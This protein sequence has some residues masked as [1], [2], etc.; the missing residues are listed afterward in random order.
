MATKQE[1]V[2][3]ILD[4]HFIFSPLSP[5]DKRAIEDLFEIEKYPAGGAIAEAGRP[6]TGLYS[7]YSGSIRMKGFNDSGKRISLGEQA[8]DS[9]FGEI[10]L[11]T[12]TNWDQQ[13]VASSDAILLK[14][15]SSKLRQFLRL[16]PHLEQHFRQQ[17]GTI[18][19]RKRLRGIL[20][21]AQYS[22][23]LA[24]E[25]LNNIG[26]KKI[27]R[28]TYAFKQGDE[29]PRL[30][31]IEGGSAELVRDM[32]EGTVVL[33]KVS[34]GGLIGETGAVT[35]QPQNYSALAVTD[36][37][38]LVIRAPEVK[39]ILDTNFE[40]KE[41][42]DQ[43]IRQ[44]KEKEKDHASALK[45]QEGM[46]QRIHLDAISESDFKRLAKKT[47]V[48]KFKVLKQGAPNEN[49]ATCL[50]MIST[51]FGKPFTIGQV[52]EIANINTETATLPQVC[53]AGEQMGF[54]T[55]YY[56]VKYDQLRQLELPAIILWEN[57][58]Y[59]VIYRATESAIYVAD[60]LT[61]LKTINRREFEAGW[62]GV[63]VVTEPTQKFKTLDAPEHPYGRFIGFLLPYKF[64]FAEAFLAVLVMNI[65]G[66]ASPLFV[67]NI[68]DKV[69]VH[70]D[71]ALLNM[72]LLGMVMVTLFT[73]ITSAA[74]SLL[75]AHV[76]A[77]IDM[78]MMSEFYRH[79]LSL[80]LR[81]FQSR[82]IG[83]ILSRFGENQKI[84]GILAGTT[85]TA[86]LD[87]LMIVLYIMMMLIYNKMLTIMVIC[88]IPI[89]IFN[90]LF[91]TP[92]LNDIYNQLFLSNAASQ[93]SLIESLHG[94]EA[95]K[96][97]ANEYWARSRWE[98]AFVENVNLGYKCAKVSLLFGI[99]S[100]LINLSA[101]I[102]IL[103]VG[104]NEVIEDKLSI[105]ELMGFNILM[106]EVM[107]PILNMVN[108]WSSL[109][110]IRIAMDRVNDV[111]IVK[112]EQSFV[113]SSG[114]PPAV[115]SKLEGRIEFRNTCFR[116]GGEDTPLILNNFN[117]IIEPG[118]SVAFVGP[119][120]C[121][122]STAIK[123]IMGF[124]MPTGGECLVDGKDITAIDL[125]SYRR[126]IGVVLQDSY[127]FSDTVAGNIALGDTEPDMNAV[128][129]AARLSSADDFIA[130]L[131]QG[132][133]TPLGEKGIQVSGGQRQ[134]ICIAR[135]LYRRPKI[136]IF[137]EATSALDN[138]SE[139]RIQQNMKAIL[140]GKT[141][142][143]I[144]HRLSTVRDCDF[145]CFMENGQVQEKGNH[146]E[147][148][149]M[150]G[151]YYELAKKQFDL[152]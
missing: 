108:L 119:S 46:D 152:E 139:A 69:V 140:T 70:K 94:I 109:A 62:D 68:V 133:Q 59:V 36:L 89:Y 7:V 15:P 136:L 150:K 45:R 5:T 113:T 42:L 49:V 39:K 80:P 56:N 54:R 128:R 24:T 79:I 145:I 44:L 55:K 28:G 19:M 141:S 138:E 147:L 90:T 37:T 18:E 135:A 53:S 77:R 12:D 110:E 114:A 35:G 151:R 14:L 92:R 1:E 25:I 61:G 99:I 87:A 100:Q 63:V 16:N 143:A 117:L 111:A 11:L 129:D 34:R 71:A 29:D 121:G 118:Q 146:D 2:R 86:V 124:N 31:Y 74:Q 48:G 40:L 130:R 103:W 47:E 102:S 98:D 91:F 67:Q 81:F 115:V 134:R 144:A 104:A 85:I 101:N 96:S 120:G 95:I 106:G 9:T 58:H 27:K 43:R 33:E 3:K 4:T 76:I 66:L 17:I 6:M 60:P 78:K 126:Q 22:P 32:I 84:R 142:I 41:K 65:L 23:D 26:V 123:M 30:Y 137:D 116:Y 13:I 82:Q 88:F 50:A 72:M 127:L 73:L 105:G 64:Y 131:Q 51:H 148:V 112:P 52:Q 149:A 122:K 97:T 107:G 20:G 125:N 38:V 83:D 21:S 93:S 10:S 57:F 132:Y 75:L 8:E